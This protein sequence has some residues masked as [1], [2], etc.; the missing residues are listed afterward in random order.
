[1]A[2][3]RH[4]T[5]Q[6]PDGQR[7]DTQVVVV[8]AGPV[9]LMLA[10]ELRLGGADVVVL[11]RRTSPTT[12]SRASTLHARTMEILDSRGLRDALGEPPNERRGHF[13]GIPLDL[14]LP[15]RYPGQWKVPQFRTEQLLQEW[16]LALGADVR[17]GWEVVELAQD[18]EGVLVTADT[19]RGP[20]R[21]RASYLVACDGEDSTV[22]ALTGAPFP[23]RR[24]VRELLRADVAGIEV[25]GRR[26]ERLERGMTV[27]ARG[28]EGVTRVM[29]HEFG[30]SA[31]SRTREPDFAE[32]AD[33]WK[34]VTGEDIAGGRPLWV[35]SFGDANRQL[36]RYREG[37]VLYAGD[38]AHQQMP[39][40]GQALNLGVQDAVNLGWKL[41]LRVRG[42][43]PDSLLDTYHSERHAVGARVLENIG[44]QALL[45]LGDAEVEPL[46]TLMTLLVAAEENR[47]R[48]AGMI[49]GLDIRYPVD[50]GDEGGD[51][52]WLGARLPELALT[53]PGAPGGPGRP[54][55]TTELL[56]TG[57]GLLLDLSGDPTAALGR[58]AEPWA[59]RVTAVA[60]LTDP[61]APGGLDGPDGPGAE[62]V[63]VRPDGHVVWAA[64]SRA[65]PLSR[66][67][68]RWFGA[69][70]HES[71]NPSR[72]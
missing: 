29:V 12:E 72:G 52:P 18:G 70:R 38:A 67:L 62:A 64:T 46:R 22:R 11:E 33:V 5:T 6:H 35:N 58:T 48:L 55:T 9:G 17:R 3:A 61:A 15:G 20:V 16:A 39:I 4:V 25:P 36:A 28:P 50:E 42:L 47:A 51:H 66:V 40:G 71:E 37:R 13:G 68:R 57:R 63:L 65:V 53:V 10:G 7:P 56:R 60:A 69:S 14:T 59:D 54:T 21:I 45:L 23:G 43:A 1:M 8:G 2:D 44:A 49:S 32:V 19:A 41:A 31:R 34:R 30:T 26:F 24:T 27:A